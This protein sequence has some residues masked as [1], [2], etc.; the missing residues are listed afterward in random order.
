MGFTCRYDVNMYHRVLLECRKGE[1]HILS[2]MLFLP[3]LA[4]NLSYVA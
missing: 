2:Y 3:F 1:E 4:V